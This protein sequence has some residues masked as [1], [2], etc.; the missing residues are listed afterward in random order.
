MINPTLTVQDVI[1]L[2]VSLEMLMRESTAC[3]L[4][5]AKQIIFKL[6]NITPEIKNHELYK[7]Y[8]LTQ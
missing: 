7:K 2:I 6:S 3:N 5:E 8:F 1:T 4:D